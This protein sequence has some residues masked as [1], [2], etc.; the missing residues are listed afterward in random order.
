MGNFAGKL[1]IHTCTQP[2]LGDSPIYKPQRLRSL[3]HV[4]VVLVSSMKMIFANLHGPKRDCSFDPFDFH[5]YLILSCLAALSWKSVAASRSAKVRLGS[6]N[7]TL[8]ATEEHLASWMLC[9]II[10]H[11]VIF[12]GSARKNPLVAL[13][14]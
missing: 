3:C 14:S 13:S 8:G 2:L 4:L 10:Q 9:L 1:S 5:N 7:K 12:L 11:I 6:Q